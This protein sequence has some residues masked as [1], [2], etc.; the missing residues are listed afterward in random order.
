[1]NKF[2]SVEAST[3]RLSGGCKIPFCS[4]LFSILIFLRQELSLKAEAK[5]TANSNYKMETKFIVVLAVHP[6]RLWGVL[7]DY[8]H[9]VFIR[10]SAQPRISAR[11]E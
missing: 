6:N 8:L 10:I 3:L 11:L 1:M 9:A 5:D 2:Q 4:L 7:V